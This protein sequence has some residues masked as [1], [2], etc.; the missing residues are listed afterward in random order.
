MI[1]V[2]RR[3]LQSSRGLLVNPN[4]ARLYLVGHGRQLLILLGFNFIGQIASPVGIMPWK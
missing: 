1:E 2:L 3:K 4:Q